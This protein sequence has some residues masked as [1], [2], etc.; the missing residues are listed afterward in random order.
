MGDGVLEG[1]SGMLN[2]FYLLL[3]WFLLLVVRRVLE[4]VGFLSL[5]FEGTLVAIGV[6]LLAIG[7]ALVTIRVFCRLI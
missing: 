3:C 6:L 5:D 7:R 1:I 4:A 2:F